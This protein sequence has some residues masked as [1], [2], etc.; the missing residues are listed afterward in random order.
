MDVDCFVSVS[1]IGRGGIAFLKCGK[2]FQ[3]SIR[4]AVERKFQGKEV[5]IIALKSAELFDFAVETRLRP[6]E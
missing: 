2:L 5:D 3:S 1:Q 6:D 4:P